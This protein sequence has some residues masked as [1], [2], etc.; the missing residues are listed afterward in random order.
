VLML[1]GVVSAPPTITQLTFNII[2]S[3]LYPSISG[4]GSK[5]AFES[6]LDGDDEIFLWEA[7]VIPPPPI[8]EFGLGTAIISSLTTTLYL[9]I[10]RRRQSK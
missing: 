3:D 7:E 5:I 8:P 4:D 2:A 9:L 1:V 6:D 10:R